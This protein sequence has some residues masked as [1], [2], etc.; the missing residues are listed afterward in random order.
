MIANGRD[1]GAVHRCLRRDL[2]GFR[3]AHPENKSLWSAASSKMLAISGGA[4]IL[5]LLR[6][7]LNTLPLSGI[8]MPLP[9]LPLALAFTCGLALVAASPAS[10]AEAHV[11]TLKDHRFTPSEL[12][13]PANEKVTLIIRN[14]DATPAEFESHALKREKIIRGNSEASITVGPLKAGSYPFF[15]EFNEATAQGRITVK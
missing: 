4:G 11:L 1:A 12:E 3:P 8:A 10:A 6:I 2:P 14:E 13:V 9:R 7:I 5:S 15:D